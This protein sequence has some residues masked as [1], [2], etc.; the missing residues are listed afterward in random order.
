MSLV[1]AIS[2]IFKKV[3]RVLRM[4][5]YKRSRGN[6]A[7]AAVTV[8]LTLAVLCCVG[9][10]VF[11]LGSDAE[12]SSSDGSPR[13]YFL[14]NATQ[15]AR[16]ERLLYIAL[17]AD[18]TASLGIPPISSFAFF[19]PCY[20]AIADGELTIHYKNGEN[21]ALFE[22]ADDNTLVFK[23]AFVPLFANSGAR[24][25]YTPPWI[26]FDGSKITV[27]AANIPHIEVFQLIGDQIN[28]WI[29]SDENEIALFAAWAGNLVLEEAVFSAG[30]SPG[31][32]EA[33]IAYL[34]TTSFGGHLFEYGKYS[35]G[36][37]YIYLE[38]PWYH[39][40]NPTEP[41]AK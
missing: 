18:G 23:E 34:L 13:W 27:N 22:V 3:W 39:I 35:D 12:S 8:V 21:I 6:I 2:K 14:E 1:A 28:E 38:N 29:V 24:Y 33:E 5:S 31:D 17:Y 11:P 37:S 9:F 10:A 7:A 4:S 15:K 41:F 32:S 16:T 36:Q 19:Y 20:Y 40:K 26:S 25:V 30:Q